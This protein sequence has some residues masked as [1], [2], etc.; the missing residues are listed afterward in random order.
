MDI[1]G[2]ANVA[3]NAQAHPDSDSEPTTHRDLIQRDIF[4]PLHFTHSFYQMPNS[5]LRDYV[6]VPSPSGIGIDMTDTIFED[7]DEPAGG[8]YSSMA[9]LAKLMK[10]VLSPRDRTLL[11]RN[12]VRE[13]LHPI[14]NW[15]LGQSVGAPWEISTFDNVQVFSKGKYFSEGSVFILVFMGFFLQAEIC[16]AITLN[17]RSFQITHTESSF[18]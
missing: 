4:G 18:W 9:D 5:S 15:G 14:Y 10:M 11:S 16:Q 3:A 2:L 6:A 12:T 17:F 1:L 7:A 13:W 8:Q